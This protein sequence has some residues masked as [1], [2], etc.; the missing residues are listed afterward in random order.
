MIETTKNRQIPPPSVLSKEADAEFRQLV[1]DAGWDPADRWM[2]GYVNYEYDHLLPIIACYDLKPNCLNVLEFGCN[3]GASA[4]IFQLL[5]A[6]VTAVDISDQNLRI[7]KANARRYGADSINFQLLDGSVQLPFP[8]GHFDLISCN[9]VLEYVPPAQLGSVQKELDRILKPGGRILVTGTSSRLWPKEVHS[10]K[11]LINYMPYSLNRYL[12]YGKEIPKGIWTAQ[13]T[14]GFGKNY[15]NL[16]TE[17][18]GTRF[19]K[20]RSLMHP[21]N[22]GF[23]VRCT[24]FLATLLSVSPGSLTHS[25]SCVLKKSNNADQ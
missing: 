9:S 10:G 4:I 23:L 22:D 25:I 19:L 17:D 7:A 8:S 14:Q 3:I 21:R 2:G 6:R 24:V 12:S 5:G 20:S 16:D 13:V 1:T 15:L 11:W 18:K